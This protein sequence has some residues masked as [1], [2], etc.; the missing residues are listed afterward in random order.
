MQGL[1]NS[2]GWVFLAQHKY[3]AKRLVLAW[4]VTKVGAMKGTMGKFDTAKGVL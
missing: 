3:R 2:V 4:H 1:K